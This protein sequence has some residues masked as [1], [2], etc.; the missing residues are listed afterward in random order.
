MMKT[1]YSYC[2]VILLFSCGHETTDTGHES[3]TITLTQWTDRMELF[4]EYPEIIAGNEIPFII[5]LTTLN[6][7]QPV[8][9]GLLLFDFKQ[10]DKSRIT[11]TQNELLRDGIFEPVI[12]I[13]DPGT[14]QL[15]LTYSDVQLTEMFD[16]GT[17]LVYG[18]ARELKDGYDHE[19]EDGEVDKYDTANGSEIVVQEQIVF[20]K[21]QQW[22]TTFKTA[23]PESITVRAS[24]PVTGEV[25]PHQHGYTEI[26]APTAGILSVKHNQEMVV[27]GDEVRKGTELLT[28][29]PPLSGDNSWTELQLSYEKAQ[30][31]YE[32][33]ERLL[34]KEAISKR[35]FDEIKRIYLL[36]KTG[37]EAFQDFSEGADNVNQTMPH[38]TLR[39]QISGIIASVSAKSGQYVTVGQKLMTIVDPSVVWIQM[40]IYEKDYFKIG[41]SSGAQVDLPGLDTSVVIEGENWQI[42]SRG[43]VVNRQNRT[44]PLLAEIKNPHR[45]FKIGQILRLDLFTSQKKKVLCVPRS[46]VFEQEL[47]RIVFVQVEGELFEKKVVRSGVVYKGRIEIVEGLTA[48]ERVVIEGGYLLKL[49]GMGTPIGQAHVH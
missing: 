38:L 16:V 32:R 20:L 40:N 33:A 30:T 34:A 41:Q 10:E 35:D 37:Y 1:I 2:F 29:C 7:F 21:E 13:P 28:I 43:E 22:H 19:K 6:D 8:R 14:Y 17:V 39:S 12:T 42:L 15:T 31:E 25:L 5:H 44:I 9:S 27:P 4:M 11:F 24:I 3:H 49:A 23:M 46:A 48:D 45:L 47:Q 36:H 26:V 18:S